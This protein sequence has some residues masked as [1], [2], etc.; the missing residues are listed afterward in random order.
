GDLWRVE[1]VAGHRALATAR[2]DFGL[3][4]EAAML[5]SCGLADVPAG[6]TKMAAERRE[7]FSAVKHLDERLAS[8]EARALL[9][10]H[11]ESHSALVPESSATEPRVVAAALPE[12]TPAYLGLLAARLA[13]VNDVIALLVSRESGH[14]VFAQSKGLPTD[15]GAALRQGLKEFGGKGGGSRDFAQG[16]LPNP[17]DADAFLAR[18]KS[19]LQP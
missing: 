2:S 10:E 5:L 15:L 16:S 3:L 12:A 1:Y 18:A 13:A 17:A 8:L 6:I 11:D 7:Q 19:L 14:V 9:R 4:A